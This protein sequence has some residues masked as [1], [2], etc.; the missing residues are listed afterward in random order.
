MKKRYDKPSE[1]NLL[2]Y[3]YSARDQNLVLHTTVPL[4]KH[5]AVLVLGELVTCP[6]KY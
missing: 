6:S 5:F 4:F 2:V 1:Y 3:D